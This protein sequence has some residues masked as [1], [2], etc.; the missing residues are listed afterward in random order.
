MQI[1]RVL[2]STGA[3]ALS[4]GLLSKAT[5]V[6]ADPT[7]VS[8]PVPGWTE[9]LDGVRDLPERI[10]AKLPPEQ[11]DDPQIRQ[12][13]GRLALSAVTAAGIDALASDPDHPTFIPQLNNY[14]SV[15]QPNADTNYRAARITPGG[16]YRLR[17]I[18]GSM[19]QLRV[20]EA[21]PPASRAEGPPRPRPVHDINTL[22]TDQEGRFDVILSPSRPEGYTGDWWQSDGGTN[23]LLLRMVGSDWEHEKEPALSIERVDKPA[24]RPRPSA[25]TLEAALRGIP[26]S[27]GFI[28]PLLV[29]RPGK[30]RAEGFVNKLKAVDLT[31]LGGLSGQFYFEGA[32]A[33][34]Q[35]EAL[36]IETPIPTECTYHSLILTNDI[37]ET[38]DWY[39]NQSSLNG[40]QSSVDSDGTLR[41]VVSGKDP[42]VPNWLDTAGYDT[43]VIQGRWM[44][45]SSQPIPIVRKVTLSELPKLLPKS[46][47]HITPEQRD[48]QI[49]ARRSI[50]QERPLW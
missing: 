15:G 5:G 13:V 31:Q 3:V 35:D 28:A 10:L 16:I 46:T 27:A 11:R 6:C 37:Y 33:L 7:S 38:T 24:P 39:N 48:V 29:D 12:E 2:R 47:P 26:A 49:R 42:G 4:I 17:G 32:Y 8:A 1:F 43:G 45:C 22:R 41:I 9:F 21:G 23:M 20:A 30:L 40:A 14:I 18:R 25:A 36:L 34:K 19:N 44:E 50:L